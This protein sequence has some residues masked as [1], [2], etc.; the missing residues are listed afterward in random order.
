MRNLVKTKP[1]ELFCQENI[2]KEMFEGYKDFNGNGTIIRDLLCKDA[3]KA[4]ISDIYKTF[5]FDSF[6][7][8]VNNLKFSLIFVI[9]DV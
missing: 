8:L 3:G 6:Q 2:T 9:M 5:E 4:F 1:E 7:R